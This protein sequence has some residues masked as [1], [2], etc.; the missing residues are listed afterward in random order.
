MCGRIEIDGTMLIA[1]AE[2]IRLL[3][4]RMIGADL[5]KKEYLKYSEDILIAIRECAD[6]QL[7]QEKIRQEEEKRIKQLKKQRIKQLNI[8]KDEL[9]N[10]KLYLRTAEFSH[11]RKRSEYREY[12]CSIYNGLIVNKEVH[13]YITK[14]NIHDED[15]LFDLCKQN[16]W[17]TVWYTEYIKRFPDLL[18]EECK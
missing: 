15:E 2:I 1:T 8:K 7:S 3:N 12:A 17:N 11:I 13:E 16:N 18:K 10:K 14:K 9:T 4:Q 6:V 5:K